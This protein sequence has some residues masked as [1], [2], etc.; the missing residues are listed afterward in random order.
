[1]A[2]AKSVSVWTRVAGLYGAAGV[3]LGAWGAHGIKSVDPE[4]KAIYETGS[5][6]HFAHTALIALSPLARRPHVTGALAA[7]GT[8]L[9]SGSMYLV[10]VNEDRA[11]GKAGPV[12]GMFL[13]AAWLS[14]AL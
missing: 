14:L 7:T 9:F 6:Y 10:G 3:G 12:G 4:F 13:V 2:A 5:R 1:M 8:A 11:Y